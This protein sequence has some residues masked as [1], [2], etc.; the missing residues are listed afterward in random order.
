MY[1][2]T[3]GNALIMFNIFG[4]IECLDC[5]LEMVRVMEYILKFWDL[6]NF[7]HFYSSKICSSSFVVANVNILIFIIRFLGPFKQTLRYKW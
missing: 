2:Q 3:L 6:I 1:S 7:V 4:P 5:R